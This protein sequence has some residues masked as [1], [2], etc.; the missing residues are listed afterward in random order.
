VKKEIKAVIYDCD[1]VMFDSFEANLAFYA[2]VVKQFGKP[3]LDR[4]DAETMRVLHTYCNKDV[5]SHLFAGDDRIAQVRAFSAT[6]DYRKLFP[7]MIMEK[8]LRETL[9]ALQGRVELAVCTN[10]ASSMEMLLE[11]FGLGGYFSCVMTAGRVINP[12]PHPE[13]LL[14][15]LEHYGI[16]AG[17]ALFVGDSEVDRQA[18]D[19]AGVPFVAYRGGMR[20]MARIDRHLDLLTLL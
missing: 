3:P 19:A 16:T 7:L 15:V 12:K 14:K 6:I 2:Q 5:L 18:A 9:D 1:G 17:E 10:R 8:G 4:G 11:S 20:A 13:P